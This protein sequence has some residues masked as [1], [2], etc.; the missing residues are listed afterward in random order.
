MVSV[1]RVE[2]AANGCQGTATVYFPEQV[3][4]DSGSYLPFFAAHGTLMLVSWGFLLPGGV[5]AAKFLRYR[6]DSLWFK[7]HRVLQPAGLLIALA[8]WITALVSPF[9]VLASGVYDVSFAHALMGTIVMALGIFQPIN[10]C[11]RPH[12]PANGEAVSSKR[13]TWEWTHK[14]TGYL[15]GSIGIVNC[16]IG[17]ALSGKFSDHFLYAL[18][19]ALGLLAIFALMACF[20]KHQSLQSDQQSE[21]FAEHPRI[22][23]EEVEEEEDYTKP[24]ENEPLTET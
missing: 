1:T 3:N 14:I 10:A 24:R 6:E 9:D 23:H 4:C 7:L 2:D 18:I 19:A 15:A 16:F 5:V 12:K 22:S 13:K 11:L 17:M 8:G 20:M 21:S